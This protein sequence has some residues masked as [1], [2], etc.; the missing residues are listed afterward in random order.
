M[1]Y[2]AELKHFLLTIDR[3]LQDRHLIRWPATGMLATM[4]LAID[5]TRVLA[6]HS[7]FKRS[8]ATIVTTNCASK[9]RSFCPRPLSRR[10]SRLWSSFQFA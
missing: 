5:G 4:L 6:F 10:T 7:V 1:V 8:A 3:C 2:L 9:K